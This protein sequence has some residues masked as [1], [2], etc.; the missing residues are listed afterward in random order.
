MVDPAAHSGSPAE[1]GST[2]LV[3]LCVSVAVAVLLALVRLGQPRAVEVRALMG[4]VPTAVASL[5]W[6]SPDPVRLC[7]LRT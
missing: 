5:A 7:V 1:S 3:A 2:G 4:R 6:P